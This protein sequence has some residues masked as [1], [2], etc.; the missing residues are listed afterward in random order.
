[1]NFINA[2]IVAHTDLNLIKM[3]ASA[4]R[5]TFRKD[6]PFEMDMTNVTKN[7]QSIVHNLIMADHSP[8]EMG[9]VTIL[10]TNISKSLLAQWTRARLQSV[11]SS[12]QHYCNYDKTVVNNVPQFVIPFEVFQKCEEINS[13][14]PLKDFMDAYLQAHKAYQDL[15]AKWNLHHSVTR[16]VENQALRGSLLIKMNVR[17]WLL[18]LGRRLCNRNVGEIS[19]A[20]WL[21]RKEL[22]KLCPELFNYAVPP[23]AR[24]GKCSEY[25]LSC[26]TKWNE[27]D[28]DNK[29]SQVKT[30]GDKWIKYL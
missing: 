19:Y 18:T 25:K 14:E 17:E 22:I 20:S 9:D 12:S 24:Y 29:W 23:C 4:T 26:G 13:S 5:L 11:V 2:K 21:M 7:D 15:Q 28:M 6:N 8:L 16:Y 10:L 1:M 27:N 3:I 30:L